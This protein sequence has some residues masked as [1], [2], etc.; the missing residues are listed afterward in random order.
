MAW[1]GQGW[2]RTAIQKDFGPGHKGFAPRYTHDPRNC[3][4]M[5]RSQ[6][7]G[8]ENCDGMARW[9]S[10]RFTYEQN[11]SKAIREP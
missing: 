2:T 4:G 11:H 8:R 1:Q 3:D 6:R 9:L 10:T 7:G 5:A